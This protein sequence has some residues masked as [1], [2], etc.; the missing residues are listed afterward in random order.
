MKIVCR[1]LGCG[2]LAGM[3]LLSGCESLLRGNVT[4]AGLDYLE[5]R[6]GQEFTY[7]APWGV[8]YTN[9]SV[10]QFLARPAGE[11]EDVLVRAVYE[12]QGYTFQDNYLAVKYESQMRETLQDMADSAFEHAVVFYNVSYTVLSEDLP[13][14]ASFEEYCRDDRAGILG[15]VA[16]SEPG[17]TQEQ[18]QQFGQLVQDAGI[19]GLFRVAVLDDAQMHGID[20]EQFD[21][22][23]GAQAYSWYFT[24]DVTKERVEVTRSEKG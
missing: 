8:G 20:L 24:L 21:N 16:I 6:Y 14:D 17:F 23:L 15:A 10:K 12:D 7:S 4:E 9:L 3:L 22:A 1:L 11:Q 19:Q 2:V 13:P 18:L 5:Q